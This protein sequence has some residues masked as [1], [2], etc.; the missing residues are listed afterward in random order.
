[1]TRSGRDEGG[2]SAGRAGVFLL[3]MEPVKWGA[4]QQKRGSAPAPSPEPTASLRVSVGSPRP[5]F[6]HIAPPSV[7]PPQRRRRKA[8]EVHFTAIVRLQAGGRGGGA[9]AVRGSEQRG[10]VA[11]RRRG[12]MRDFPSWHPELGCALAR[13]E[14]HRQRVGCTFPETARGADAG[15][16]RRPEGRC[17][18]AATSKRL[19]SPE[20]R[21]HA[22]ASKFNT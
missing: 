20:A 7:P 1:M 3:E 12:G 21:G 16:C 13:G 11:R 8:L 6:L 19:L 2:R 5:V 9:R 22:V 10:G 14:P 17:W 18:G 4:G 15:A